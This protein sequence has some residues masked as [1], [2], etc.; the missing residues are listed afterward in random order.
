[1]TL[2]NNERERAQVDHLL[3]SNEASCTWT[4]FNLIEL[5]AKC[6]SQEFSNNNICCRYY[7][8]C[9]TKTDENVHC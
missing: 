9:L 4:S 5:L 6:I 3:S 8:G 1:M 7:I 2:P